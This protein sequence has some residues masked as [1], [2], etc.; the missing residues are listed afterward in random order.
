MILK[1]KTAFF[2]NNKVINT[3][4][5]GYPGLTLKQRPKVKSDHI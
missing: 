2:N 5:F 1:K 4:K 3:F